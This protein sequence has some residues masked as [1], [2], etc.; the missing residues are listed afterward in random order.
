MN[1][2]PGSHSSMLFADDPQRALK[3]R[4][5]RFARI[6]CPTGACPIEPSLIECVNSAV[7]RASKGSVVDTYVPVLAMRIVQECISRGSCDSVEEH[8][9]Y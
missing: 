9:G 2:T 4:A 8:Y 3:L 5:Y 7:Q 1:D 6:E